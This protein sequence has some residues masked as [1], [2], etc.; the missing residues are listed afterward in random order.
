MSE[1]GIS[2]VHRHGVKRPFHVAAE[3][4]ERREVARRVEVVSGADDDLVL[5]NGRRRRAEVLLAERR[6][7]LVPA[8]FARAGVERDEVAVGRDQ[9][10]IVT[11]HCGA[12]VADVRAALRA[13]E[14]MPQQMTIVGVQRP[15]VVRRRQID[16]AVH[17]D[18]RCLDRLREIGLECPRQRQLL[19]VRRCD[20]CQTAMVP[21]RVV[22]VVR[23]PAVGRLVQQGFDGHLLRRWRCRQERH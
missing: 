18:W 21:A 7:F 19:H 2:R 14:V 16:H 12:A 23:R 20:L 13:P 6:V 15:H 17:D 1:A 11:P 8:L 3:R 9:V 4:I 5:D 10:Q 22:T